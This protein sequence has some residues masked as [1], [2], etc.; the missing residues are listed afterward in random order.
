MKLISLTALALMLVGCDKESVQR[1]ERRRD[2]LGITIDIFKATNYNIT[3]T[4]TWFYEDRT[5]PPA[6]WSIVCD[7]AKHLYAFRT[8]HGHVLE[9]SLDRTRDGA[10]IQAWRFYDYMRTNTDNPPTYNWQDCDK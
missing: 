8:A 2:S 3:I 4:N 10:V 5:V 7:Q 6:G 9:A 1:I